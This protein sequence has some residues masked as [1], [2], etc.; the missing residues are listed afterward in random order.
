MRVLIANDTDHHIIL[1]RDTRSWSHRVFWFAQEG[2]AVI[3][4][5]EPE[6]EFVKFA[7][8]LTGVDHKTLK[9]VVLPPG[10][11]EGRLFDHEQLLTDEVIS[12][13]VHDSSCYESIVP[14]WPSIYISQFAEKT[15][16]PFPGQ[17]LFAQNGAEFCNS[18]SSF[19]MLAAGQN[20]NLPM[21]KIC[22]TKEEAAHQMRELLTKNKCA[23]VKKIHCTSGAGNFLVTVDPSIKV[24]PNVGSLY[25]EVISSDEVEI[26]TFWE[27]CWEWATSDNRYPVIVEEYLDVERTIYVEFHSQDSGLSAGEIGELIYENGEMITELVPP[28]FIP[29]S[30]RQKLISD[31]RRLAS[32]YHTIGYRGP[33]SPDAVITKDGRIFFTEVNARF[34]GSTHLYGAIRNFVNDRII[35]QFTT[36]ESWSLKDTADF[37]HRLRSSNL[38]YDKTSRKGVLPVVPPVHG[39]P[40]YGIICTSEEELIQLKS[41]L[42]SNFSK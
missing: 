4:S 26:Q 10:R 37:I 8:G 16:V 20:I 13:F 9:I 1:K 30:T 2:D 29:E 35:A 3:L 24:Q 23:F 38:L 19:R 18:K 14:L 40:I 41:D 31:G 25:Y 11:N 21:G 34:S 42:Q 36:K 28:R 32:V 12:Q 7:T 27:E 22:F 17:N 39:V 33:I 6:A 5:Y 15:K